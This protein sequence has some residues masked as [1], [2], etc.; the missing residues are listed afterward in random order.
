VSGSATSNTLEPAWVQLGP[1]TRAIHALGKGLSCTGWDVLKMT[2][3]A[4]N[5][6]GELRP[7]YARF[8][9]IP[10]FNF[11]SNAWRTGD[12]PTVGRALSRTA[13]GF[14]G[15]LSGNAFSEFWPDVKGRCFRKNHSADAELKYA[16]VRDST[17]TK[18]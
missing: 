6:D 18:H 7:A 8:I 2:Y 5:R 16:G 17:S 13:F 4:T 15:R 12:D 14:R 11:I 3:M 1:K 10:A 9:A